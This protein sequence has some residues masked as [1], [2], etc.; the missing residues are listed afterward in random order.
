MIKFELAL[1]VYR[2]N[3]V[4]SSN[5]LISNDLVHL[6]SQFMILLIGIQKEVVERELVE[7]ISN[8]LQDD[9]IPF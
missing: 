7:T 6:L 2:D 5:R 3:E 1:T 8:R 9:D 4:S